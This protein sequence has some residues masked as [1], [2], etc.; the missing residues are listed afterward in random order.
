MSPFRSYQIVLFVLFSL[1][2]AK[3]LLAYEGL[4]TKNVDRQ[5]IH[6]A[7]EN[8]QEVVDAARPH[9]IIMADP[10]KT[11]MV[12]ETI[13]ID[14]P[15][16]I[17]GLR[18]QVP[19]GLGGVGILHVIADGFRMDNFHLIG[20]R[21]SNFVDRATLLTLEGSNFVVEQGIVKQASRH[22]IMVRAT[23]ERSPQNGVIRDIIGYD[24]ARD[25]VSI[26]GHG[27]GHIVRNVVVERIRAY[28]SENR[29]AVE[30]ADGSENITV[31]DIY[32][33]DARYGVDFQ[34]HDGR[35]TYQPNINT[36]IENV[37]V[38]RCS[39]AVR[40][41]TSISVGKGGNEPPSTG[42]GHRNLTIRNIGGVE[43]ADTSEPGQ[44]GRSQKMAMPIVVNYTD[45][46][47]IENVDIMGVGET[48]YA[49]FLILNSRNVRVQNVHIDSVSVYREAMLIENSSDVYLNSI[50]INAS[51]RVVAENAA[52][53]Y[54]LNEDGVYRNFR[55]N[56]LFAYGTANRIILEAM[57]PIGDFRDYHRRQ[58]TGEGMQFAPATANVTLKS[59]IIH[60][61]P[62]LVD[63]NI[64]VKN[65]TVHHSYRNRK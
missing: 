51:E 11:L 52:V 25:H 12:V 63:D 18:A 44:D 42:F 28:G 62:E 6:F 22:G 17:S 40:A 58:F 38:R 5:I 29:G 34:D 48:I 4:A 10:N 47:L 39:H 2:L 31:R 3:N 21:H 27:D 56:D 41:S 15:L 61:D 9:D 53:R 30:V 50:S 19:D 8:L 24:I 7:G 37:F 13:M 1:L 60:Y 35:G 54:R 45:N 26:E 57:E 59:F 55:V 16:T 64:G 20:N 46:V 14:K 23:V 43:W 33:E 32:A 65:G 49:A 36:I